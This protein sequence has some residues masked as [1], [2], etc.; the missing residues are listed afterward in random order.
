[1]DLTLYRYIPIWRRTPGGIVLYRC[2]EILGKG[3]TVQSKDY[4]W[5]DSIEKE[6]LNMDKQFLELLREQA[7]EE[8]S[9][10]WA[11]IEEAIQGFEDS[12]VD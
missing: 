10:K 3:F 1:M 7:P 11:S 2:F 8:R 12:F 4:F 5:P 6:S 9:G